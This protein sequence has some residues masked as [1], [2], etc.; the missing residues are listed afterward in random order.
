MASYNTQIV[1]AFFKEHGIVVTP[2]FRFDPNRKWRADFYI[3]PDI[4]LE[5]EGGLF[6]AGGGRHNRGASMLR[7]FEKYNRAAVL[8]YR[9]LKVTPQQLCFQETVD[10]IQEAQ[11]MSI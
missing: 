4:L 8:G 9:I 3:A 6:V 7:D 2:E 11:K 10:M 1:L 5:V